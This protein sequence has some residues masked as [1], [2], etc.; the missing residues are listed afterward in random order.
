MA[1]SENSRGRGGGR[2]ARGS[3][4]GRGG[5]GAGRG[6]GGFNVGPSHAPSNA[7]LGKAKKI[8]QDLIDRARIKK[9]FA[10]TLKKEGLTSERLGSSTN[11]TALGARANPYG[12]PKDLDT[13]NDRSDGRRRTAQAGNASDNA[14]DDLPLGSDESMHSDDDHSLGSEEEDD[15][16]EDKTLAEHRRRMKGKGRDEGREEIP[17]VVTRDQRQDDRPQRW[18]QTPTNS[19]ASGS[20]GST[21]S[22]R[23]S[24]NAR[25][26]DQPRRENTKVPS[27]H[28]Q[29]NVVP[30]TQAT[31]EEAEAIRE[32]KRQAYLGPRSSLSADVHPSRTRNKQHR[33]EKEEHRD[34]TAAAAAAAAPSAATTNPGKD[35]NIK[36]AP[37]ARPVATGKA[38]ARAPTSA[39]SAGKRRDGRPNLNA[40]MGLLLEQIQRSK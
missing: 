33:Q 24:M 36:N 17:S 9:S 18:K 31:R 13:E 10:K 35:V 12:Q 5:S 21:L 30:P 14:Q 40:R 39:A 20:N 32:L 8:K 19:F 25:S 3:R 27:R 11:A 26:Q 6:R 37:T 2:G 23:G 15:F 22:T 34:T 28:Q 4:G 38:P 29:Q 1:P 7:Y 16:E